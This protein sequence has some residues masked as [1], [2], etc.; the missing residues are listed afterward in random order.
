M[1]SHRDIQVEVQ[2]YVSEVQA[3][4]GI[5]QSLPAIVFT[6]FLGSLSDRFGRKPLLLIGLAGA[7]I[8]NIVFLVNSYWYYELKVEFLLF[9]CL[10]DILGG[11]TVFIIGASSLMADLTKDK[12]R[13]RR[14]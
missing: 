9:E 14:M 1:N 8:L 5:L 2:K 3:Y 13:T 10:Q 12:S 7:F 11:E 6:F 4:N